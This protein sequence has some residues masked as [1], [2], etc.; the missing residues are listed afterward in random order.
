MPLLLVACALPLA[1]CR[2]RAPAQPPGLR[3][4]VET[5]GGP[6]PVTPETVLRGGD[7]VRFVVEPGSTPYLVLA[8]VDTRGVATIYFP[9]HGNRSERVGPGPVELPGPVR[10]DEAPGIERVYA[11]FSQEPI[12]VDAARKLIEQAPE[13]LELLGV[14]VVSTTLHRM[15]R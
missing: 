7:R 2:E 15:A 10:L 3:V 5:E 1:S 14:T 12:P 11:L 8:S 6:Q 9:A 13:R 4:L